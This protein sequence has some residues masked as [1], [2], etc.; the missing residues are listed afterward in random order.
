M[1]K[2]HDPSVTRRMDVSLAH[3]FLEE[4]HLHCSR[5]PVSLVVLTLSFTSCAQTARAPE[6]RTSVA[7]Q[8]A[9][10]NPLELRAFV[11]EM[12]KGGELHF[13]LTGAVYAET[14]LRDAGEDNLCVNPTAHT[15]V[16]NKGM[17]KSQPARA[18][19]DGG[20]IP[21]S[22]LAAHQ[23]VYDSMVDAWSMR[24]FVPYAGVSGHDHFFSSSLR[25]G[26]DKRHQ[27]EWVDEVAVRAAEQNE[28]YLEIQTSAPYP[29]T[30]KA[31]EE[32]PWSNDWGALRK[33]LLDH[34]L[35]NDI[36]PGRQYFDDLE[37]RRKDLEHCG[38]VE[39]VRACDVLV[40][41]QVG[42]SRENLPTRVFA[43][44]MLAME[45]ASV[46]PRIVGINFAQPEDGLLSMSQYHQQMEMIHF[47]HP[48][49]PQVH[50]DLHAGE[51]A[52]GMVP[53]EGMKFHIREAIELGG[54]E[55]IGH[56][57]DVMYEDRPHEL[58]E[59]MARQHILVE[60]N[61]TSNDVILGVTGK[62][63]P[64]PLYLAA[65]VPVAFSTDDEGVS[66]IDLTHE[67]VRAAAEFRLGYVDLKRSARASIEHSFL[68]G[69]DL[70]ARKDDFTRMVPLCD[71]PESSDCE[72]FRATSLKAQQEWEL[73]RRF[74]VFEA[75]H[76]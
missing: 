16:P 76:R 29:A 19:C 11:Q 61:L 18:I 48:F 8:K 1:L 56:G 44:T 38:T 46:D 53:P 14:I 54:A 65:H 71:R 24:S 47:L 43:Q 31:V 74:K 70:W 3:L 41:Y 7:F 63:H 4:I 33:A 5:F 45:M 32:V 21:A 30:L 20:L 42:V 67:Y 75:K 9:S 57:V 13:H 35:R 49:Y 55:R 59:E 15:L 60:I 73:E 27:G 17:T 72:R 58:L 2:L 37:A 6:E 69:D 34:G 12:P 68:P 64:L 52:F 26:T 10:A 28:Q 23:D 39:A 50:V 36:A 66:R 22:E 51:L 40:R 25:A 62:Q